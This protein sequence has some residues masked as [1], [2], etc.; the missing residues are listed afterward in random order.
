MQA[1]VVTDVGK[2]EM[3]EI[4]RPMIREDEVLIQV[5]NAGVCGSDLHLF[6]G[7]HAFRKPPAVLGHEIAGKIVEIGSKVTKYKVGDRVTVEPQV[8]CGEC[9]L[10]RQGHINLCGKK[11]VPGTPLWLG[12][13]VEYFPAP[14]QTLYKLEDR[15]S[16]E[17]GTLIEPLAVAVHALEMV[18]EP[19]KNC[20]VI[21]GSG[22]IGLL[23]LAAAKAYGYKK[24][25]CTDT[26]A[27][28]REM[29]LKLG[30][31]AV[32]DPIHEDV[33]EQVMRLT[34]GKGADLALIAAGAP[35]IVD[36]AAACVK[37][38]GEVGIVAMITKDIPVY[39][40][41]FVFNELRLFGSMTYETKDFAKAAALVNNGLPIEEYITQVLPFAKTQEALDILSKKKEDVIKVLVKM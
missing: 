24:I 36:Q 3:Q 37:K 7:T 32:F 14:E 23:L 19:E 4:E 10:C 20:L 13:F 39:T 34:D 15:V 25:I 11:K 5:A 18:R 26:M 33:R 17:V 30:A 40:Y 28:N 9:E 38:T 16:Y 6:H 41:N 1:A 2:V 31:A 29:A 27:F 35:N 12:T 8:G 21:L 22:T